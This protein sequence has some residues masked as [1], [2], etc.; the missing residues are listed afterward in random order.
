MTIRRRRFKQSVGL[1][2]RLYSFAKEMRE[3]ASRLPP[4]PKKE[5]A[6]NR[7]RQADTACRLDDWI[8]SSGLQPP[9]R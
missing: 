9:T 3:K 2:D 4:G 5:D 7:A 8:N 6:L 1:K